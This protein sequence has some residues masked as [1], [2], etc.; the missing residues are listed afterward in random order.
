MPALTQTHCVMMIQDSGSIATAAKLLQTAIAR[1]N[2][3]EETR[4]RKHI[5][6]CAYSVLYLCNDVLAPKVVDDTGST[7]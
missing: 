1:K 5:E 3:D 4:L 2:E 7:R 6:A